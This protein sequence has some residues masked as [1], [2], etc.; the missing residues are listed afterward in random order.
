MV[1]QTFNSTHLLNMVLFEENNTTTS[2]NRSAGF[3][4]YVINYIPVYASSISD[5][6]DS[7]WEEQY[8]GVTPE[9]KYAN[10][11]NC[12]GGG[13]GSYEVAG[14]GMPGTGC[15]QSATASSGYLG[16][17]LSEDQ[18]LTAYIIY[19]LQN[20]ATNNQNYIILSYILSGLVGFFCGPLC[21]VA[22]VILSLHGWWLLQLLDSAG[23]SI[24]IY[25]GSCS[26]GLLVF[27]SVFC[28]AYVA[29]PNTYQWVYANP[30]PSGF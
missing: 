30:V 6:V 25:E 29:S 4:R 15:T 17:A 21:T 27:V 8:T 19:Y 14:S 7:I 16:S 22:A 5:S 9:L 1:I 11:M 3:F 20:T 28:A 18:C 10:C 24:G 12:G 23:G 26:T 2:A 13:G